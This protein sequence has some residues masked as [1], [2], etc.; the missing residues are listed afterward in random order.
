MVVILSLVGDGA[1]LTGLLTTLGFLNSAFIIESFCLFTIVLSSNFFLASF[2]ISTPNL[3][4]IAPI[5]SH[6]FT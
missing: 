1:E 2:I 6:E 3:S 5:E 4:S